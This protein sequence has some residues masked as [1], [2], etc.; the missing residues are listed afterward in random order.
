MRYEKGY[1]MPMSKIAVIG[2]RDAILAFSALGA[3]T[4]PAS[5]RDSALSA[6]EKARTLGYQLVFVTE[7]VAEQVAGPLNL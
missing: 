5:D 1:V 6:I 4:F 3:D 2:P 7:T